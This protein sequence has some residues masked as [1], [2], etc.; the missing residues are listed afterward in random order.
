MDRHL[1]CEV[2]LG[3]SARGENGIEHAG[4]PSP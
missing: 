2:G 4:I 1:A 3:Q